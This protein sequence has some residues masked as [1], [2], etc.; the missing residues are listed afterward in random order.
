[1]VIALPFVNLFAVA[2]TPGP[3]EAALASCVAEGWDRS[4]LQVR[5][6][7][8]TAGDFGI[9]MQAE[10]EVETV[11]RNPPTAF[12]VNVQRPNGFFAWHAVQVERLP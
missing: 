2:V 8:R 12:R 1:V 9:S 6:W 10:V 5:K 7:R 3:E 4:Q 11:G